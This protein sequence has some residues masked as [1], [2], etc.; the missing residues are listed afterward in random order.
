MKPRDAGHPVGQRF[1]AFLAC[2]MVLALSGLADP[3]PAAAAPLPHQGPL[4]GQCSVSEW[5]NP[6]NFKRCVGLLKP[7]PAQ[8]LQCVSAPTPETPD[9]GMPGWFAFE[10]ASS[11]ENGPKGLFSQ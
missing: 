1:F 3:Y 11:K 8:V 2:F 10:P 9:A 5:Q 6:T 4:S 7:V